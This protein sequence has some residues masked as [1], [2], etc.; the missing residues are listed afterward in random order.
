MSV[1]RY[2]QA[3]DEYVSLAI[4]Q[5]E[6]E[7]VDEVPMRPPRKMSSSRV[8]GSYRNGSDSRSSG[9]GQSPSSGEEDIPFEE[10]LKKQ[11]LTESTIKLLRAEE[12]DDVKT[13]KALTEDD[14]NG[15]GLKL[16]QKATLRNLTE[17]ATT[18]RGDAAPICQ[19][20]V[21]TPEPDEIE[22]QCYCLEENG[23][24]KIVAEITTKHT[25]AVNPI[26]TRIL[27]LVD[28]SGSMGIK[29]GKRRKYSKLF[30]I[31]GFA[32][33]MITS[34][35][36]GDFAGL[37]TFGEHANVLVPM[38]EITPGTREQMKAKLDTLDKSYLSTKTNL[39]E[40]LFKA[41]DVFRE[42]SAGG[43]LLSYKNAIIV[44]SDGEINAGTQEPSQL[45]HEVRERIRQHAH[46]LE[47]S[48]NQW[49]SIS[50][51]VL[52]KTASESMFCLS[53]FCSSDAFYTIDFDV[54]KPNT[55][56][57]LFLP[58]LM[59]KAAVAWN[60]S[61]NVEA[62]NGALLDNDECSQDNK[63]RTLKQ[64]SR[65]LRTTKSYF[66]YDI[67]AA[68]TRHIGI[69]INLDDAYEDEVLEI[70]VEYSGFSGQ[71]KK[72]ISVITKD[73][74]LQQSELKRG[75]A[76]AENYK[77]DARM[78]S[79]DVLNK[80]A[81]HVKDGDADQSAVDIEQGKSSLQQLLNK[82]GEMA[83]REE[84]AKTEIFDYAK[85]LMAN[86]ESLLQ[87]VKITK[88]DE[89]EAVEQAEK[90]WLKI[91]AVSSAITREAPALAETVAD[92]SILCPLPNVRT[93]SSAPMRGQMER[94]YKEQG[95]RES[96]FFD[97][98]G[99]IQELKASMK[100]DIL[101]E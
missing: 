91:K 16:G 58:V 36:D 84:T 40:G 101:Q 33:N 77:N 38:T 18:K 70:K 26:K 3:A 47:E 98:E 45:V 66:Y 21:D 73:E 90:S 8:I 68:S 4:L 78:L 28:I 82:Y 15:L 53:K 64:S 35:D 72:I 92:G 22:L 9:S 34:L 14:I 86:M 71:R 19:R 60:V 89:D 29:T 63:V 93:V 61:V 62:I 44:L 85:S 75:K 43:D 54:D 57:D 88:D 30:R 87:S 17:S 46:G 59:R 6:R 81:K 2:Q 39:G 7:M 74:I 12:I 67:P 83:S 11:G 94:V 55:E 31:K 48:L 25:D 23:K 27:L 24:G 37:V 96:L 100:S 5:G 49:V 32:K 56:V 97:F 80:A 69:G 20:T 76:I 13:L 52:G 42:A 1:D 79:E 51:V 95:V 41:L 65:G 10:Y 99:A 50:T